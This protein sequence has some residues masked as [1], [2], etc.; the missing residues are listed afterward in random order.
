MVVVSLLMGSEIIESLTCG[1]LEENPRL[2]IPI[3]ILLVKASDNYLGGAFDVASLAY[4]IAIL[5]LL[6]FLHV[7]GFCHL[8]TE[9]TETS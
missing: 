6:V 9:I 7:L 5:K 8:I 2:I 3:R 4:H 1:I